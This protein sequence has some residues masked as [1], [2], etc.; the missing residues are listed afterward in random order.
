MNRV[1]PP[2]T[3][4]LLVINDPKEPALENIIS[5][6]QYNWSA[7]NPISG[8][9]IRRINYLAGADEIPEYE[10]FCEEHNL[11]PIVIVPS[12]RYSYL[13]LLKHFKQP[14]WVKVFEDN[15]EETRGI[16]SAPSLRLL[17][18]WLHV[19][20]DEEYGGPVDWPTSELMMQAVRTAFSEWFLSLPEKQE[21]QANFVSLKTT[22]LLKNDEGNL[23]HPEC[24]LVFYDEASEHKV[25]VYAKIETADSCADSVVAPFI[26]KTL[27]VNKS[28]SGNVELV[29][30]EELMQAASGNADKNPWTAKKVSA[31]IDFYTL[32]LKPFAQ[33]NE[34]GETEFNVILEPN[35]EEYKNDFV[36]AYAQFASK[37]AKLRLSLTNDEKT[38][39]FKGLIRFVR[40]K[41]IDAGRF[42]ANGKGTL[43]H[44]ITNDELS[45][46]VV[47]EINVEEL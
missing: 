1:C 14:Y 15:P 41:S 42:M 46:G 30:V 16:L 32:T 47:L 6:S 43:I 45:K 11:V 10:A 31:S 35:G 24:P 27:F 25:P 33:K 8:R 3:E 23:V 18:N 2:K 28:D 39:F 22:D 13:D 5:S 38:I 21:A 37:T 29:K 19:A 12:K 17:K 40:K 34:D 26:R 9:K 7:I 20:F 4:L 44:N 36:D